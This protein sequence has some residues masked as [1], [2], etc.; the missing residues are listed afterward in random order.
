VSDGH[1]TNYQL[2]AIFIACLI[3]LAFAVG[4]LVW[5]FA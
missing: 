2:L 1:P 5:A 3:A 4:C